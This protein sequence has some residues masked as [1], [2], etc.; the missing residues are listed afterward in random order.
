M[1]RTFPTSCIQVI[2]ERNHQLGEDILLLLSG[3]QRMYGLEIESELKKLRVWNM[4]TR[5]CLYKHLKT[6]KDRD[7]IYEKMG[8]ENNIGAE[9]KY[10]GLTKSGIDEVE[11]IVT[12]QQRLRSS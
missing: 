1:Q 7:L 5:Q 9:R 12:Y 11:R 3:K 2:K 10:Y 4:P 6:L 8:G